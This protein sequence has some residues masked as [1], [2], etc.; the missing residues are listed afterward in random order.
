MHSPSCRVILHWSRDFQSRSAKAIGDWLSL[1]RQSAFQISELVGFPH[2][3]TC[4]SLG[5]ERGSKTF[6]VTGLLLCIV[7]LKMHWLYVV[8]FGP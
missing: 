7:Q 1:G 3:Q 5:V 6:Y 8:Y 2:Q 4:S